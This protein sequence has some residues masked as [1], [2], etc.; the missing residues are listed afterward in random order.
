MLHSINQ[1][2]TCIEVLMI[3]RDKHIE[4]MVDTF[5]TSSLSLKNVGEIHGRS[6]TAVEVPV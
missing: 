4:N 1:R 5:S 6:E 3:F 2:N